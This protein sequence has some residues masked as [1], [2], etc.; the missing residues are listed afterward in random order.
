MATSKAQTAWDRLNTRQRTYLE[1]IY[2]EDQAREEAHQAESART[3]DSTPARV[4]RR[5]PLNSASSALARRLRSKGV[6]DPGAGSTLTALATRGLVEVDHVPGVLST[7]VC[8]RITPAGRAAARA[9]LGYGPPWVKPK[10]A[11]S[12]WLWRE[13]CKVVAAGE[14]GLRTDE[15]WHGTHGYLVEGELRRGNR[16]YL[17][18]RKT[19]SK[20]NRAYPGQPP[21]WINVERRAY[22]L[23]DTGRAHYAERRADYRE[24]YPDID[25]PDVPPVPADT[26]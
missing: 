7:I 19:W 2:H 24:I 25:A 11:L 9:G 23:T 17:R 13:F 3:W 22:V 8:V 6:H 12:E 15:L 18:V 21:H 10:W 5:L 4:W 14:E 1:A 16:P 26:P 20:V